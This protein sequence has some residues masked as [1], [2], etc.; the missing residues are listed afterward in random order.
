MNSI[1][2]VKENIVELKL[3]YLT[4]MIF[5][6]YILIYSYSV[7]KYDLM[8]IFF[9]YFLIINFANYSTIIK[10]PFKV[11]LNFRKNSNVNL[12]YKF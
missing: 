5:L 7:E 8:S 12:S 3:K 6:R 10:S 11:K 2:N 9:F 4:F 1:H